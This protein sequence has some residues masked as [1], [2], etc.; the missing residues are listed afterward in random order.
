VVLN[1]LLKIG[2]C[3]DCFFIATV[4]GLLRNKELLGHVIPLDNTFNASKKTGCYHFR[5]WKLGD[6]YDVGKLFGF[7]LL[8]LL[9]I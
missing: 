4:I 2:D 1:L 7:K 3:G 9:I 8:K 5:F 6:W